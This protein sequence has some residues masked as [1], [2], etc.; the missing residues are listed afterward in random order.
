MTTSAVMT[1]DPLLTICLP[2]PH[3]H[4]DTMSLNPST[5]LGLPNSELIPSSLDEQ[6][7]APASHINAIIV[8]S[9]VPLEATWAPSPIPTDSTS[10]SSQDPSQQRADK[11]HCRS[12]LKPKVRKDRAEACERMHK[13]VKDFLCSGACG[14]GNWY[15]PDLISHI[16][17]YT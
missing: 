11:F 9:E 16:F 4:I 2:L 15:V 14:D 12:C 7:H 6:V 8:E 17:L 13:G 3:D 5:G 10:T 1:I